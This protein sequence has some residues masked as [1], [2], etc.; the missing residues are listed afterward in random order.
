[1]SDE[2]AF[3]CWPVELTA[4]N[5]KIEPCSRVRCANCRREVLVPTHQLP[6]VAAKPLRDDDGVRLAICGECYEEDA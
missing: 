6:L 4:G 1:M 5:D 3:L 2:E